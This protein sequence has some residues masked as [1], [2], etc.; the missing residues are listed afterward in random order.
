MFSKPNPIT[1]LSPEITL[2][3][4]LTAA[5]AALKFTV[6]LTMILVIVVVH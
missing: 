2:S 3:D 1:A 4:T 5:A 6:M